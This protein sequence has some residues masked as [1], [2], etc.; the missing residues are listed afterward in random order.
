MDPSSQNFL[1]FLFRNRK[2]LLMAPLIAAVAALLPGPVDSLPG[3]R[4]AHDETRRT[5]PPDPA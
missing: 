5:D 4:P 1:L 2:A 3:R